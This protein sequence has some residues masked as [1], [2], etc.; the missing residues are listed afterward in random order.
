MSSG[1]P[2]L[3]QVVQGL[4]LGDNV[5]W[6]VENIDD[7]THFT[8]PFIRQAIAE[9]RRCIYLRFAPHSRMAVC[10]LE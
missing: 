3:D 8:E 4:R 2:A 6:R 9:G 7:Y 1:L 5:V 10:Y